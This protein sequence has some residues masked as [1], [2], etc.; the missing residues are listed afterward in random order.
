VEGFC[1]SLL[2]TDRPKFSN[3]EGT[4]ERNP[5]MKLPCESWGWEGD[6]QIENTFENELVADVN[7]IVNRASMA[8]S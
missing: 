4:E 7:P 6:W 3:E 2:P 5:K 8:C 1:D